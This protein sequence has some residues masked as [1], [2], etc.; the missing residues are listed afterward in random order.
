M[1][2]S[3]MGKGHHR[4]FF[5]SSGRSVSQ[6]SLYPR[7]TGNGFFL[8][9]YEIFLAFFAENG[10]EGFKHPFLGQRSGGTFF[11]VAFKNINSAQILSPKVEE[12]SQKSITGRTARFLFSDKIRWH[13]VR[14]ERAS[15][16]KKIPDD[17][18]EFVAKM[19]KKICG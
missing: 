17:S 14:V 3:S 19:S 10:R 12:K 16:T 7:G 2:L 9:L 11:Q 18:P 1:S 4:G 13:L 15:S 6:G 8:P 5:F